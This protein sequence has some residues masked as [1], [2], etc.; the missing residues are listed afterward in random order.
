MTADSSKR[1][2]V[3]AYVWPAYSDAPEMRWAFNYAMNREQLIDIAFSGM[4]APSRNPLP[5]FPVL[6]RY[7]DLIDFGKYP[8]EKYDPELTKSIFESKGWVM[9]ESTGYYEKDGQE[10][11]QDGQVAGAPSVLTCIGQL[12]PRN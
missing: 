8:V 6:K 12:G 10:L 9:N 7:V 1:Y 4:A 3:A 11:A 2:D 5:N